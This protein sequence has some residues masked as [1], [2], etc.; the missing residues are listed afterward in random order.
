[1]LTRPAQTYCSTAPSAPRTAY[2]IAAGAAGDR[3]RAGFVAGPPHPSPVFTESQE[4]MMH[5][6]SLRSAEQ[7]LVRLPRLLGA[8]QG[9][10]EHTLT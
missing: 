8:S 7:A 1:M 2:I 9:E 3:G 10:Q 5:G 4:W 6:E